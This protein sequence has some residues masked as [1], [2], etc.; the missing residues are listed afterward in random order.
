MM[1]GFGLGLEII[2]QVMTSR[3]ME[4]APALRLGKMCRSGVV[5]TFDGILAVKKASKHL[6]EAKGIFFVYS[7]RT[8]GFEA[9]VI[10]GA[11]YALFF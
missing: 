2:N 6:S 9:D 7:L 8:M 11:S 1:L 5:G 4:R 3:G 10:I